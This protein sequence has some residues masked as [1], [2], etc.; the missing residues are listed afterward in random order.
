MKIINFFFLSLL[1]VGLYACSNDPLTDSSEINSENTWYKIS[2]DQLNGWDEGYTD[3]SGF[4][5]TY[6]ADSLRGLQYAY[7]NKSGNTVNKLFVLFL[8]GIMSLWLY[9]LIRNSIR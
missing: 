7:I 5:I 8:A 9:S 1:L 3:G 2:E 6:E 4:Y